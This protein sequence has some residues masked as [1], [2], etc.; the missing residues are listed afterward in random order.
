MGHVQTSQIQIIAHH[1]IKKVQPIASCHLS[2]CVTQLG[3][4]GPLI[5]KPLPS[6]RYFK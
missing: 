4:V 1:N 2:F 6:K 3:L 5:S